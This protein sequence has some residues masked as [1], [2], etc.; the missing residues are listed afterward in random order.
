VERRQIDAALEQADLALRYDP[1]NADARLLRAE[2]LIVLK[3]FAG[4]RAELERYLRLRPGDNDAVRLIDLCQRPR[5]E[6]AGYLLDVAQI[7][8]RKE[9]PALADVLL[10]RHGTHSLDARKK[11]LELY[12]KRIDSAWPDFGQGLKMDESGIYSLAIEKSPLLRKLDPL[13]GMPL[14][15]L[16]LYRCP[17]VADLAPLKGMP[18]TELY[19]GECPLIQDL[20]PLKGMPLTSLTLFGC[21]SVTDLSPLRGMKLGV[22]RLGYSGG[23]QDLGPLQ[24][25]PLTQLDITQCPRVQDLTPLQG[26]NLTDFSF[27]P[28]MISSKALAPIRNMK[29][30]RSIGVSGAGMPAQ[31]FWKKYDAGEFGK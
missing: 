13:Q 16:S 31:E 7:L 19:L 23:I 24:G 15:S 28:H 22:L 9:V 25:M 6:E 4:A 3:D 17:H 8:E 20:T 29:S 27:T 30:L 1:D 14:T 5:P 12:R 26:M 10:T 18:L 2:V 21:P 11:L